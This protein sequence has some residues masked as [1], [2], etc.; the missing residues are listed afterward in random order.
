MKILLVVGTRPE[1]IKMLPVLTAL[2][3]RPGL[4]VE[5]C[6]TAQHRHMLDQVLQLF[7]VAADHDLD[8]MRP[9]Q[10]LTD[11]T[12]QI[13]L[14]L[15]DLLRSKTYD[16]VLVHGDTST[17]LAAA[18]AAFYAR[19]PVGHVE[20]GLRTMDL[21]M[22]WPEEM[23]RTVVGRLAR[24]HF[25]PTEQARQNLLREH[26]PETSIYVTGNT[27]IDA[28]LEV[29]RR[30]R[31]EA[32][33]YEVLQDRFSFLNP[34]QRLLLVTGHRR[35]NF[36]SG[37]EQICQA[38]RTLSKRE[39]LQIV[40]PVH[41]NPSVQ[42]PVQRILGGAERVFLIEPQ[43]YL[44]F[45]FLMSRAFL[46]LTDSGGVQEEAPALGVPVLVMRETTERPEAVDAGT[47]RLVGTDPA[48]M[49]LET[50]R[51]LNNP[52]VYQSMVQSSNPYGDGH[53]SERIAAFLERL[54]PSIK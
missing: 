42:E 41:L 12:C 43:E 54:V 4:E 32:A 48:R 20:A 51:L 29:K 28:L 8:I 2:R 26:V 25:A 35:E 11:I 34:A 47:V 17:A 9:G 23:N 38:L 1:G 19:I 31:E 7:D 52:E 33:L 15:R 44:P 36:G 27:V 16:L 5:L 37:L 49:V 22:P 50:E 39:D 13:L 53:A 14:K 6:V 40:Y 18:L 46:I 21:Q 3:R 24:W 30:L 45:V 10:E